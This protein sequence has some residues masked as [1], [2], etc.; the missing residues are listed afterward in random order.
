MLGEAG[1]R[2]LVARVAPHARGRDF[3]DDLLRELRRETGAGVA[4]AD[5]LSAALLDYRR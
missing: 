2:R 3:L 1:L 4:A 5:D